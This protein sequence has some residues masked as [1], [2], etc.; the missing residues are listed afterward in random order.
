[1]MSSVELFETFAWGIWVRLSQT[2]GCR[3]R[4]RHHFSA[5]PGLGD[6]ACIASMAS[7]DFSLSRTGS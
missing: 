4:P 1:M 7:R 6:N 3:F 2:D 5:V